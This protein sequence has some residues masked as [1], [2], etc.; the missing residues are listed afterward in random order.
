MT[1]TW[2]APGSFFTQN[3][4][5]VFCFANHLFKAAVRRDCDA[6]NA[7]LMRY[8]LDG[9]AIRVGDRQILRLEDARQLKHFVALSLYQ[10]MILHHHQRGVLAVL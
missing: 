5:S 6:D 2:K 3:K 10:R 1:A 8:L 9:D 4:R 7:I